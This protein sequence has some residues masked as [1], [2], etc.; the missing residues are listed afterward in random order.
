MKLINR[1]FRNAIFNLKYAFSNIKIILLLAIIGIV[2]HDYMKE[3][4]IFANNF[5]LKPSQWIFPL[6]FNARYMRCILNMGIIVLFS[7]MP[8]AKSNYYYMLSRSGKGC[9]VAGQFLYIFSLSAIYYLSLF[10]ICII[11]N[12][13]NIEFTS[14]WGKI[15][16]LIGDGQVDIGYKTYLSRTIIKLFSPF[17]ATFYTFILYFLMSCFIGNMIFFFNMRFNSKPVGAGLSAILILLDLINIYY[18]NLFW[19]SPL[20]WSDLEYVNIYQNT[21]YPSVGYMIFSYSLLILIFFFLSLIYHNK[22]TLTI[23]E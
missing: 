17:E 13:R 12:L 2:I 11:V 21:N 23:E 9:W 15:F 7:D 16:E 14:E 8:T 1:I 10:L 3:V 18:P 20:S 4:I 19:Y 5:N 6:I 22:N